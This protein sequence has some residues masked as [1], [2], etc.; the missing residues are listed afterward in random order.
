[1]AQ[2]SASTSVS[3]LPVDTPISTRTTILFLV[4]ISI[5]IPVSFYLGLALVLAG[6]VFG[7][8]L[9]ALLLHNTF[10]WF[11]AI[12]LGYFPIFISWGKDFTFTPIEAAHAILLYGG[13]L[14]W[15]FSKTV[16]KRQGIQFSY[17]AKAWGLLVLY[18]LLLFPV[19]L[20]Q[21]A[22]PFIAFREITVMS[23]VLLL[24][25]MKY[26]LR[27][28]AQRKIIVGLFIG[29]LTVVAIRNVVTFR[30]KAMQAIQ[31]WQVGASRS[32]EL[33]HLTL[34]LFVIALAFMVS[35]KRFRH[36]V[37]WVLILM[38]SA[39]AA[40]LTFYRTVW[41]AATL[42][43]IFLGLFLGR[44][45]W[46]RV[47][48]YG[49]LAIVS[50]FII[51]QTFFGQSIDLQTLG[52]SLAERALTSKKITTDVSLRNRNEES[53][54]TLKSVGWNVLIGNGLGTRITYMNYIDW[55]T[56]RTSWTHNA[57]PWMIYHIGLIGSFLLLSSI[58]WYLATGWRLQRHLT[59]DLRFDVETR[60]QLRALVLAGIALLL[61]ELL[62]FWTINP[63]LDRS[64]LLVMTLVFVFYELLLS[65]L[66][67][68]PSEESVSI[69]S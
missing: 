57:F 62:I 17:G 61:A 52:A 30:Q 63:I 60:F 2:L 44:T 13:I 9:A 34:A 10:L 28:P 15:F 59:R 68:R 39:S 22:D 51:I 6:L 40:L 64:G 32:P 16:I 69:A 42:S 7:I 56:R 4:G 37:F 11:I 21:Q 12:V 55:V 1:M 54:S 67:T 18:M 20:I 45:Y 36:R 50:G 38:V 47:M 65:E 27:T 8:A 33:F 41:L 31:F 23:S 48:G 29:M 53:I 58:L 35:S 5:L 43:M 19:S 26:E 14:W 46:K 25:P 24:L 49:I 66:I 3:F